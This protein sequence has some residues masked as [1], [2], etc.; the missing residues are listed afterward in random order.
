MILL[1]YCIFFIYIVSS[2]IK[3]NISLYFHK[4]ENDFRFYVKELTKSFDTLS[5][6]LNK[7]NVNVI[8][9]NECSEAEFYN[10]IEQ[11]K[12]EHIFI[13]N[14]DNKNNDDVYQR[15]QAKFSNIQLYI[16]DTFTEMCLESGVISSGNRYIIQNCKFYSYFAI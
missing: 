3:Y 2:Q 7:K 12:V 14:N 6:E 16:F 5:N 15:L 11:S 13:V 1:I 9:C 10:Q 8:V 4:T